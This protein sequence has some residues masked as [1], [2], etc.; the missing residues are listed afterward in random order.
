M[1]FIKIAL[2]ILFCLL[3]IISVSLFF[4]LKTFDINKYKDGITQKISQAVGKEVSVGNIKFNITAKNGFALDM[5][6]LLIRESLDANAEPILSIGHVIFNLDFMTLASKREVS[7]KNIVLDEPKIR[8]IQKNRPQVSNKAENKPSA[9]ES[10]K[11]GSQEK[12][13]VGD[14]SINSVI[15]KNGELYFEKSEAKESIAVDL[16]KIYL[17]VKDF[18]LK[19]KFPFEVNFALWNENENIK[20]NG[21]AKIDTEQQ[22][23]RIDDVLFKTDLS[24]FN[25]KDA[26]ESISGLEPLGEI[27]K[28]TG[29]IELKIDQM[30]AGPE[31]MLV[32]SSS[33]ELKNAEFKG[34]DALLAL[35]KAGI[36]FDLSE[37]D[38]ILN[39]FTVDVA[40]GKIHG[41]G[42]INEYLKEAAYMFDAEFEEL[43]I[44]D[45]LKDEDMPL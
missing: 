33:G 41:K 31:G 35:S 1:K 12:Q 11:K 29:A 26:S 2:L 16:K 6:D 5:A 7:I 22:Q 25:I 45:I 9:P 44:A 4:F 20:L 19:D 21:F 17:E 8:I 28:M 3:V 42:R 13:V 24:D 37:S 15:V 39:D 23:V 38:L 27:E 43:S 34:V 14:V 36:K 30:I 10:S 18:N 32:M 40:S